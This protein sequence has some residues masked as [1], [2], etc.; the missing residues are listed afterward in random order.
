MS[1]E[2]F[3]HVAAPVTA[4]CLISSHYMFSTMNY[5]MN[6]HATMSTITKM[7]WI[8]VMWYS[9]VSNGDFVVSTPVVSALDDAKVE[10]AEAELS[11]T[12]CLEKRVL[13]IRHIWTIHGR[14]HFS[15]VVALKSPPDGLVELIIGHVSWGCT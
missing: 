5:C 13:T 12:A 10:T 1:I 11:S 6:T 7:I 9:G 8:I 2:A 14:P 3:L 15:T 4:I